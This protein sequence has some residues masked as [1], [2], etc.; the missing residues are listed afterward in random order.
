MSH[1]VAISSASFARG[2]PMCHRCTSTPRL[3]S[4]SS[5]LW[6]GPATKPSSES[7]IWQVVSVI[8]TPKWLRVAIGF[9]DV[10]RCREHVV[11][12][13]GS[14]LS[15]TWH[16]LRPRG[17]SGRSGRRDDEED[18]VKYLLLKHYRGGPAPAKD[19][20]PMDRW[21]PEEVDAHMQYMNDFADRL[22]ES[23]EF[24]DS[25]ALSSEGAFVR[26][27]GEGRPPVTD[28]PFAEPKDLSA[29]WRVID[30]ESWARA[31]GRGG[32][33]PPPRGA[34]GEPIHEWLQ[35]RPLPR[36]PPPV[37]ERTGPPG[38]GTR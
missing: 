25:Q 7:D 16:R 18:P 34:G 17:T 32:E 11:D 23:G 9:G 2:S 35:L 29:G 26:A 28:G 1:P 38:G 15:R 12:P 4:G 10:S 3:P 14:S 5:R 37:T 27:D 31:M 36:C 19:W 21:T 22:K 13:A 30:V 24:V 6:S 33:L 20:A 8:G